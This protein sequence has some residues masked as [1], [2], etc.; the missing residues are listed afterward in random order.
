MTKPDD[1][2]NDI[3]R[4]IER[5]LE[6]V[7]Q[8]EI[9][10]VLQREPSRFWSAV[11][12]AALVHLSEKHAA[13]ALEALARNGLLDVRIASEVVYRFSPATPAMARDVKLLAEAYS[14]R[15]HRVL[16]LLTSRRRRSLKD[17]S[18]AFRLNDTDNDG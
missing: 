8:L 13:G 2:P 18:D 15:R 7:E 1:L 14:D 3:R 5:R 10:M 11:S 16:A 12:V 4:F 17:F 6:G 9:L